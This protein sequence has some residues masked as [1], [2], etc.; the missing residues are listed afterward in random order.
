MFYPMVTLKNSF[1]D[2]LDT[3]NDF[4]KDL[5]VEKPNLTIRP[6]V[7]I[8]ETPESYQMK[9]DIPGV[10]RENISITSENGILSL[11][12]EKKLEKNKN[13]KGYKYYERKASSYERSFRLND[14]ID[15]ENIQ[16][17]L[18]NGVVTINIPK[19]EKAKPKKIEVKI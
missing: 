1:S 12:A 5:T 6:E 19:K 14:S 3:L 10:D 7:D 17:S 2:L 11:K 13:L 4:D 16:A 9:V 15:P 18:E 8:E